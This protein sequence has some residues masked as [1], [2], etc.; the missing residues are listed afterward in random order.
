MNYRFTNELSKAKKH[1][2]SKGALDLLV[3]VPACADK[4]DFHL[5]HAAKR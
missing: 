4:K 5:I 3:E 1:S 2:Y